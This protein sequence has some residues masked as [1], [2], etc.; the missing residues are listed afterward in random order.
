MKIRNF[1]E[2][3][4]KHILYLE[5]SFMVKYFHFSNKSIRYYQYIYN[6]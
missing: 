4:T 3:F 1:Y 2:N 6:N 5:F